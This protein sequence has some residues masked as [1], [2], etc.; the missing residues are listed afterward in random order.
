MRVFRF[1]LSLLVTVLVTWQLMIP[2]AV[3]DKNLPALGAFFNPFSGFWKNAESSSGFHYTDSGLPGLTGKAQVVY[4]DL[5]VPHIFAEN[6]EDAMRVQGYVT[7]QHRLWQMDIATRKASGRLSEILG[8]RTL[9]IDRLTR[10]RGMVFAA[11]NDVAAWQKSP[12]SMKML[13]AYT[14][15]INAWINSL[16]PADYPIEFK[17]LGYAPEPW[18]VLKTALVVENMADNLCSRDDDLSSTNALA[19]FGKDTFN[20]LYPEWNPKQRPIIPDTGQWK[21]WHVALP[22]ETGTGSTGSVDRPS[23]DNLASA[24]RRPGAPETDPYVEGSNNWAVAGSRTRS[25]HPLLANDPHLTLS[26]PS[27]WFQIQIHT[28]EQNCY[29]VSLQGVPGII[30]GFNENIAWGVTNVSHDVSDWYRIQWADNQHTKYTV[31]GQ[32]RDVQER[33]E[34]I[35]IKGKEARRDTVRYT[36]WGPVVYDFDPTHPLR[37][38]AL[39][40]I[41][42]D[43]PE[44]DGSTIFMV[45][46]AGKNYQD[47]RAALANYDCPA[48]NFVFAT[49]SGDVA[50]TVQGRYPVR[51]PQQGR[52][53]LDGSRES[54]AWHGFI[55][56]DRVPAMKNPSRGFVFSANQHSTPPSY[57]YYYLG[58][59][60][61]FRSRE[62]YDRLET[63]RNATV[64]SMKAVQL[65]NFS[66]RAA[67][68]LPAMLALLDR[69][70]LDE[71]GKKMA[72]E[73]ASWNFRYDATSTAAP[74]FDVWY[75]SCYQKTWDEIGQKDAI[76]MPES[77]R[78]ID[79]LG[80]DTSSIF[81]DHPATARREYA[82]DIVNESFG[83]MQAYFHKNPQKRSNWGQFMGFALKHLAQIDAFSR[84]DVVVG[85][86]RTAPNAMQKTHGPS[87]R[88]I[89]DMGEKVK[90]Y[91]VYPGGQSGNPGSPFY[92][93]MVD[94]WAKGNYYDLLLLQ[95]AEEGSS[96]ILGTQTFSPSA[97]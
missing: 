70:R 36:A 59:F 66:R 7:A 1:L 31:D 12:G 96:R 83:L 62:I 49:R 56:A 14:E 73:L 63:M 91:G 75:D 38:C 27:I 61:D 57:P 47:Y 25:G 29:G 5:L 33:V 45:L 41:S 88:M 15:G 52:F 93:N 58:G 26:L 46:N 97:K 65:D 24:G 94:T 53:I 74:L 23:Y 87:W 81:F 2:H 40:W 72:V 35:G 54:N 95:S 42:H 79:L 20:Y 50:I 84:L 71:D 64:D 32:T 60:E 68:G 18:S 39:R 86:H 8:E 89:V 19:M 55:P 6:M 3:G 11:E 69:N 77:W 16:S 67:D 82:R 34:V 28:P 30:I 78:F 48:Q 92:D 13:E 85:G 22:A 9:A 90:G 51:A 21:D 17:L 76:L 80:N 4:D 43:Q 44:P 10:R 37:D